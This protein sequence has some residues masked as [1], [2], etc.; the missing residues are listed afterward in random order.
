[1]SGAV[2]S[3]TGTSQAKRR[4]RKTRGSRRGLGG[5]LVIILIAL[6]VAGIGLLLTRDT[7][8]LERFLPSD[9]GYHLLAPNVLAKRAQL[10]ES[11]L[12]GALPP[13]LG[14]SKVR[15]Q[16]IGDLG[17]PEWALRNLAPGDCHFLGSDL[18]AFDDVLLVTHTTRVGCLLARAGRFLP[19][20][21]RDRAGGLNL[22]Y[23]PSAGLY[24]AAR[25]R[26]LVVSRSRD[27]LI[28]VLT[29]RAED[30]SRADDVLVHAPEGQSS[31]D[32]RGHLLIPSDHALGNVAQ[33]V[34][35]VFR[36]G[37]NDATFKCRAALTPAWQERLSGLLE[38]S[39]A[40]ALQAPPEGMLEIALNFGMTVEELW[41]AIG[42]AVG[43]TEAMNALWQTWSAAPDEGDSKL[44]HA[45]TSLLGPLGPGIGLS[46]NGVD[47]NEIFPAPELV[48]T[49]E[50]V[51][52]TLSEALAALPAPPPDALP[53][54]SYLRY[55]ADKKRLTLP[56]LGGPAIEPTAGLY[57]NALLVSSSATRAGELLSQSPTPRELDSRGNLYVRVDPRRCAGAVTDVAA[58]LAEAHLLREDT[59]DA[60]EQR[61]KPWIEGVSGIDEITAMFTADDGQLTLELAVRGAAPAGS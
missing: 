36:M 31:E 25:G 49:F 50:A 59:P 26:V 9:A 40:R 29:L 46:W 45:L 6:A 61:A 42:K 33:S 18:T 10:A 58:L 52:D 22:C 4:M 55:D 35:F 54:D 14:L 39:R 1:M 37:E 43:Q 5:C 56:M 16:L 60:F 44:S 28:H 15:E 24:Y 23:V 32:I 20:V 11:N 30:A 47:L 8:P 3:Y 21:K 7:Y 2:R 13:A 27:A 38:N 57:G 41:P 48:A 53:W 19:A 51:P 17:V 34:S 12:W